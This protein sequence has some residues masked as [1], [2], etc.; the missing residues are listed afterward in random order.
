MGLIISPWKR[1]Q[2]NSESRLALSRKWSIFLGPRLYGQVTDPFVHHAG[3]PS[4]LEHDDLEYISAILDANPGLYL[5][6]G[7]K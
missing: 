5:R 3:H 7:D 6:M 1:L 2:Q 4:F